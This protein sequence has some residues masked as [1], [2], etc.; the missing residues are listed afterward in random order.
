MAI[1]NITG[2]QSIIQPAVCTSTT[3]PASP[4][5]GQVIFETDTRRMKVWLG[6]AWSTGYVHGTNVTVEYLVIAGGGAGGADGASNQGNGGGGAGGYRS[7]VVGET[8]GK[9]STAETTLVLG[10]GTY[11]VTVGA[12]A[13]GAVSANRFNGSNSTF[14][15]ITSLGGGGGGY[16]DSNVGGNGG[17]GGGSAYAQPVVGTGT[18]GQGFD[19]MGYSGTYGGGGGGAGSQP[20]NQNGGNGKTSSISGIST[21]YAGGGGATAGSL[22]GGSGGTGGGGTASS[23]GA[24]TS[25][26]VNTGSGGGAARSS[27][28]SGSGGS[29]IVIVRYLT[30]EGSA[31]T[32]TGGTASTFGL[33]TIRTF[34]ASG[35]L[36]IA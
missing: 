19:G 26:T 20:T 29:G 36:V 9:N 16:Y 4:Y 8:S 5:T 30:V 32:I 6:S 28:T 14:H 22:T 12:G 18:A 23:G 13:A 35:S 7:S 25:G 24:A 10:T 21:T 1:N 17:C 11:I 15:T 34:T 27:N 3:R 2:A 33:Y 31:F